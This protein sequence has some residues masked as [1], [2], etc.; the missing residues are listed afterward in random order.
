MEFKSEFLLLKKKRA[1]LCYFTNLNIRP[2][3]FANGINNINSYREVF[4]FNE[5]PVNPCMYV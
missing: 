5:E 1:T 4:Q 3:V 2:A